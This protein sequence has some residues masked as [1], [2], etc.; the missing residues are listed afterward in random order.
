MIELCQTTNGQIELTVYICS[1]RQNSNVAIDKIPNYRSS[2]NIEFW[3]LPTK[4]VASQNLSQIHR[5]EFI[6]K[7]SVEAK[8]SIVNSEGKVEL[9]ANSCY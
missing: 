7:F 9:L 3:R 2:Q 1:T 5:S 4:T 6:T 8:T